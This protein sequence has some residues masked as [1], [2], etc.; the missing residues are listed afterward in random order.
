MLGIIPQFARKL[1]TAV[2]NIFAKIFY[3]GEN[4]SDSLTSFKWLSHKYMT[5]VFN[6]NTPDNSGVYYQSWAG[7]I[8]FITAELVLQPSWAFIK[9]IQGDNDG[10]VPVESA[11][12]GRF[13]G[14]VSGAWWCGGVSHWNEIG[15]LFGITPGFNA[16]RFYANMVE[17]LRNMGF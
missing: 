7:K 15:H 5:E 11:K 16:P 8:K 13:R 9:L 14:V 12:W 6:P 1:T 3:Y 2:I 10:L 4:S 17:E